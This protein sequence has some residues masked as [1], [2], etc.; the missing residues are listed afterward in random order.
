[1]VTGR[2]TLPRSS[3]L[4]RCSSCG[5]AVLPRRYVSRWGEG[6]PLCFRAPAGGHRYTSRAAP[7]E[8]E[9]VKDLAAVAQHEREIINARTSAAL[10]RGRAR[11]REFASQFGGKLTISRRARPITALPHV[12]W[13]EDAYVWVAPSGTGR[14]TDG[15]A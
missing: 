11:S 4:A 1:M 10:K 8:P 9:V 7:V 3:C 6:G 2:G 5:G 12:F 15:R 14:Y 13:R